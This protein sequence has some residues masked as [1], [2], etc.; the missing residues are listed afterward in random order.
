MK[1]EITKA[2]FVADAARREIPPSLL[3]ESGR[4]LYSPTTTLVNGSPIYFLGVN[5]GELPDG[6]EFH[7]L[8]TVEED[9]SRL[10]QGNIPL[11]GYLDETWKGYPAGEAPIQR[12]ARDVFS[13]LCDGD[14]QRGDSLLRRSPTSNIILV[15]SPNV[16]QLRTRT[17]KGAL[18]LA[19]AFW[20]FHM[21]VIEV[22][23]P[24]IV[25]THA[26]SLA[27]ALAKSWD[28]GA[29]EIRA[30]GWGGTLKN[31]YAWELPEGPM[32]LAIPNLARYSPDGT[33][34]IALSNFFAE[35]AIDAINAN[36][37]S[38]PN[39]GVVL[40]AANNVAPHTP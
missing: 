9:L 36:V 18:E 2:K 4:A 6:R 20:P 5:P 19:L 32:F 11:H 25:L 40:D 31:C 38:E 7:D 12:R 3:K 8:L 21:A 1:N 37:N 34:Q 22:A 35:F 26:V 33:R 14:R 30:S 29:G 16:V 23:R 28:L 39:N 17:G 24:A 10:E 13:I 15:R 27:R